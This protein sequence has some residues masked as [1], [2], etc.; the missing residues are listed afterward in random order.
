MR[1]ESPFWFEAAMPP[2]SHEC[3]TKRCPECFFSRHQVELRDEYPW[4]EVS[5]SPFGLG[6]S[7]CR[8]FFHATGS[9]KADCQG[10]VWA[11]C[12]V[13]AYASI[14][15]RALDGHEK[16]DAHCRAVGQIAQSVD[17]LPQSAP[18]T[19]QFRRLLEHAKKYPIGDG[20][21]TVGA[22]KKCRKML[23]CLAEASRHLKR[24]HWVAQKNET[25]LC[26]TTVFQDTRNGILSVRCTAAN[27]R[28]E[29]WLGHLGT[30]DVAKLFSLDAVGLMNGFDAIL[31]SFCTPCLCPPHLD[32]AHN[33]QMDQNLYK[34]VKGSIETFVSD[35]ASDEV[36]AGHMLAGQSTTDMYLPRFTGLK[37]VVRDKPHA[38]RRNLSRGWKADVFLQ[39]VSFRFIFAKDSPTRLIQNSNVFQGLFAANIRR[40]NPGTSAVKIQQH[41]KDLGF[42]AHRFESAS[43][44][45]TRIVLLW[46]AFIATV[47][48]I[49]QERQSEPAGKSAS[50]FLEWLTPERI[51]QLGMLADAAIENLDLTRLVD[52][53]GFPLEEL[54]AKLVGFRD[55]LRAL[56]KGAPAICLSTGCTEIMLNWLK[57][58]MILVFPG[59]GGRQL[60]NTIGAPSQFDIAACL[61]R[62]AH[63]VTLCEAT[64]RAEFPHFETQQAFSIFN[65]K[66]VE[67]NPP[68][69]V[70]R[71]NCL[72]RLLRAF[73]E[74]DNDVAGEEFQRVWHVARRICVDEGLSSVDSWRKAFQDLSRLRTGP[75]R[76]VL[77]PVLVR[78]WAAGAST[79][80]VEQSFS[81]ARSLCDGLQLNGH[82]N[83]VMEARVIGFFP[84]RLLLKNNIPTAEAYYK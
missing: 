21:S 44:P 71:T 66:D 42:A 17:G 31:K 64:I 34:A 10:G 56:F 30:I 27:S 23:W 3:V 8:K 36:R 6:C 75:R 73:Q 37:I 61:G 40:I 12:K 62:M 25:L 50:S 81:R 79:S 39:E 29:R 83:D 4:L 49:A 41:V 13:T 72:S 24:Q 48:Q 55:R 43:K 78:F 15:R 52:W 51:V 19:Q 57:N 60:T 9:K 20:I 53:Q 45:M 54:P 82:C 63:W 74:P 69:R 65:V 28:A 38:T 35:A 76:D 2:I 18:S 26:S 5:L 14:Q 46:P 1:H 59:P 58:P 77:L 11:S 16:S 47:V 32:R 70:L 84:V 33:P 68:D 67:G 80:G 7:A 22:Q